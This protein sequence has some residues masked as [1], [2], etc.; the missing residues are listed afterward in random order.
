MALSLQEVPEVGEVDAILKAA[1]VEDVVSCPGKASPNCLVPMNVSLT[2]DADASNVSALIDPLQTMIP[3]QLSLSANADIDFQIFSGQGNKTV[4]AEGTGIV[5]VY[6]P[7]DFS[8]ASLFAELNRLPIVGAIS[9]ERPM[10]LLL[11]NGDAGA[12]QST[13]GTMLGMTTDKN[14]K[15]DA[16]KLAYY[17]EV[18]SGGRFR[19]HG[20]PQAITLCSRG[21]RVVGGM[22]E[23]P[24]RWCEGKFPPGYLAP[25]KIG[26]VT[27]A[28]GV[29]ADVEIGPLQGMVPVAL[30]I[31]DGAGDTLMRVQDPETLKDASPSGSGAAFTGATSSSGSIV[32]E[33]YTAADF[34][35]DAFQSN[36]NR[37]PWTTLGAMSKERPTVLELTSAA[38]GVVDIWCWAIVLNKDDQAPKETFDFVR[39]SMAAG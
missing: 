12:E 39:Q 8:T 31:T 2:L 3:L 29:A 33:V 37:F 35:F 23:V 36:V 9:K 22:A 5:G 38:G 7:G 21:Y 30:E 20:R 34:T 14:G 26:R 11:N 17:L 25:L 13:R 16:G 10:R 32:S 4:N 6:T 28:A 24:K 18:L 1:G 15:V 27:L 19:A